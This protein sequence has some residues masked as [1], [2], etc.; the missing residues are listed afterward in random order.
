MKK[1][2]RIAPGVLSARFMDNSF[3]EENR[4]IEVV[5]ASEA[6]VK[7]F[8]WWESKHYNEVLD[9][10]PKSVRLQRLENGAPLLN[11]HRMYGDLKEVLGV[12]E[13]VRIEGKKG[14]ATVRFSDREDVAPIVQDVRNGILRN[15]S[16][17][18]AIH[19]MEVSKNPKDELDTYRAVDWE[20]YEISL[21]TVP[22]DA[23]AQVRSMDQ[24]FTDVEIIERGESTEISEATEGVNTTAEDKTQ[25]YEIEISRLKGIIEAQKRKISHLEFKIEKL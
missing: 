23:T 19:K 11:N 15:I 13:D 14:I 2:K 20:P 1:N 16:V 24:M 5:F 25:V 17:G 6:P 18:Y 9:L 4:T 7:R 3:N 10:N 12:V 21:V 8:D 22:A